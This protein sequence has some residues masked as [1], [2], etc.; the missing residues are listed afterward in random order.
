MLERIQK[1]HPDLEIKYVHALVLT[2]AGRMW[3]EF[4]KVNISF[5]SE[6]DTP[7]S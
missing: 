7:Q 2:G 6:R 4:L 5:F 1:E 3:R